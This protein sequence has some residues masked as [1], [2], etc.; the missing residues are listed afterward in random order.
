MSQAIG[1]SSRLFLPQRNFLLPQSD[2]QLCFTPGADWLSTLGMQA[3]SAP[4][5]QSLSTHLW[6]R[7]AR[8]DSKG[9]P[10]TRSQLSLKN[11]LTIYLYTGAHVTPGD[12]RCKSQN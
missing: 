3:L 10:K 8:Q 6:Y 1:F 2:N 11:M 7:R 5:M 12:Q 9:R 4:C